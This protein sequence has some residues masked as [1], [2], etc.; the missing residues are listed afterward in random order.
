M[1]LGRAPF[2]RRGAI[3][4]GLIQCLLTMAWVGVNTWV[5]LDLVLAVLGKLGIHGG[6]GLEYVVAAA[7]ML[8]QLALA[9]YG[10]YAIRTFEKYTVPLTV[11]VMAIMTVLALSRTDL[12]WTAATASTPADKLSS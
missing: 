9:L 1:V 8:V 6:A 4:P 5:V 11:L 10:F 2:G 3:V 7:I 12:H